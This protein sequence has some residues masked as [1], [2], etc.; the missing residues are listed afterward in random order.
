MSDREKKS[1]GFVNRAS[2]TC[3]RSFHRLPHQEVYFGRSKHIAFNASSSSSSLPFSNA[4]SFRYDQRS[5]MDEQNTTLSRSPSPVTAPPVPTAPGPRAAALQK[6]YSD[7]I[8]HVLKT[9]SY[10]N[11]SACFP[12]PA[13]Q[14]PGSLRLLHEQF[15]QKLGEGMRKEFGV[16]MEERRVV[17][18]LNELDGLVEEARRKKGRQTGGEAPVPYVFLFGGKECKGME[19]G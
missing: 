1:K 18:C 5:T 6:L 15:T 16:L 3:G 7:A 19:F 14:V 2:P 8:A 12:T 13:A 10:T 9:C 17:G 4:K 11:F